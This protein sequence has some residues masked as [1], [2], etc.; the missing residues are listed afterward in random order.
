MLGGSVVGGLGRFR[1][2]LLA[3]GRLQ[4][5][6]S[7]L[8]AFD[9]ALVLLHPLFQ[10][11]YLPALLLQLL[12]Q[13]ATPESSLFRPSPQFLHLALL[14]HVGLVY[15]LFGFA[16]RSLVQGFLA[17]VGKCF[18]YFAFAFAFGRIFQV[19]LVIF[20]I[21]ETAVAVALVFFVE[22]F[23]TGRHGGDYKFK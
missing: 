14:R 20:H 11:H 17:S 7:L 23:Q 10:F 16:F 9:L 22:V 5:Q 6:Y 21:A 2:L 15:N 13:F 12:S 1:R 4:L 3:D 8:V 18:S 19:I